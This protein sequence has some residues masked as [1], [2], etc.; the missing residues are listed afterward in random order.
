M[1]QTRAGKRRG[2][3]LM[4]FRTNYSSRVEQNA[5]R[6]IVEYLERCVADDPANRQNIHTAVS[7]FARPPDCNVPLNGRRLS[8]CFV[9]SL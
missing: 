6:W 1:N 9:R 2:L 4:S 5:D 8:E 7:V 3:L